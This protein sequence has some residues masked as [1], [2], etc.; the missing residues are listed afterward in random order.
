MAK[1]KSI[2]IIAS[3]FGSEG[4]VKKRLIRPSQD[5][6]SLYIHSLWQAAV[7]GKLGTG[8]KHSRGF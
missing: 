2:A 6:V 7:L 4:A 8:P 1:V 5:T 3:D